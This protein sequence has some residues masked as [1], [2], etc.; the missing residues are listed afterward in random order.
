LILPSTRYLTIAGDPGSPRLRGRAERRGAGRCHLRAAESI[1]RF[2]ARGVAGG[3]A[4][5]SS[6]A[7]RG[8]WRRPARRFGELR[9]GRM[10]SLLVAIGS[11]VARM[12]GANAGA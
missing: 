3:I 2:S 11:R 4:S 5:F 7:Q 10:R 8:V 6:Q 12:R 9:S 1:S